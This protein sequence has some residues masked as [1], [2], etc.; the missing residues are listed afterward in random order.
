VTSLLDHPA[1]SGRYLFP[2]DRRLARPYIAEVNGVKLACYY[3]VTDPKSLTLV[4]FH[5]NGEAV[6]DYV[7]YMADLYAS[8]GLNQLLIEYREYGGSSGQAKVVEMLGDGQAVMQAVGLAPQQAIVFG[9]S[10]GSLYAIELA[11]RQPDIAGLILD[12]GIAHPC[13]RFLNDN[14][15]NSVGISKA[16]LEAAILEHLDHCTKLS[17]YKNPLLLLHAQHDGLIDVSEAETNYQSSNSERKRL[18]K[19]PVGDHNSIFIENRREYLAALQEFIQ[20]ITA[21]PSIGWL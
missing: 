12:S 11:C 16:D 13:K 21:S 10:M 18:V 5:G 2:Q 14:Y 19:F 6:A 9:R 4:H 7:P 3:R 8:L 15:L 17:R 20:G 1:I